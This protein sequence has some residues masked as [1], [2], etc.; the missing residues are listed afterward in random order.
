MHRP[1]I[2]PLSC[3][4]SP[5]TGW[6][7]NTQGRQHLTHGVFTAPSGQLFPKR[8]LILWTLSDIE[9]MEHA[10]ELCSENIHGDEDSTAESLP[11][12]CDGVCCSNELQAYQ[13]TSAAILKGLAR[14]GRSFVAAW[15]TLFP[16]L[17]LCVTTSKVFCL[18]CRYCTRHGLISFSKNSNPAFIVR[19]FSNW[20]KGTE[21]FNSHASSLTHKEAAMKWLSLG[22]PSLPERLNSEVL[23]LQ[24]LRRNGLL[25]QLTGL[26][27]LLRQGLAIRGHND[28]EGNLFQLLQL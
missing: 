10:K 22:R 14:G 17:T 26:K 27:Y 3:A 5:C 8:A 15:F 11:Q 19:G 4:S 28:V 24:K 16:W 12:E 9:E 20:K 25:K 7:A 2:P 13:P 6:P 1:I 23:R 21:K 18:Y